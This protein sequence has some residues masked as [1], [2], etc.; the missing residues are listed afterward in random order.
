LAG[1][2]GKNNKLRAL[3]NH[4]A[5]KMWQKFEVFVIKRTDKKLFFRFFILNLINIVRFNKAVGPKKNS[6]LVNVGQGVNVGPENFDK[7]NK[8]RV[9]NK[10]RAWKIWQ[11]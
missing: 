9:L 2:F 3:N 1:K 4:R 10:C 6:E 11:K 5:W 8:H 7:K